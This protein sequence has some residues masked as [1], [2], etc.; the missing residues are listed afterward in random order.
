MSDFSPET[1]GAT[2]APEVYVSCHSSSARSHAAAEIAQGL[3]TRRSGVIERLEDIGPGCTST[4]VA[5]DGCSSACGARLLETHGVTPVASFT[6]DALTAVAGEEID[7]EA[8]GVVDAAER[9][10]RRGASPRRPRRSAP[11][12]AAHPAHGRSHTVDDYLL[13]IDWLTSPVGPCG[14]LVENAPT[15]AAHVSTILGVSR[16]TA[17][18]LLNRLEAQGL[19]RRGPSKEI[20]LSAEGRLLADAASRSHR[21]LERFVVETLGFGVAECFEQARRLA[22]SFDAVAID[23]LEAALGAPDR[24][25]HGWP[26]DPERARSEAADLVSLAALPLGL[27]G[28]V[29]RLPEL[30]EV[31]LAGL[32]EA[33]AVPGVAV[34]RIGGASADGFRVEI[35]GAERS[36]AGFAAAVVL[37]RLAA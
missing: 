12:A 1:D 7:P 33:G 28:I 4:V 21:I 11:A 14:A 35:D 3:A 22:P 29:E 17:G 25:P 13:A 18:E 15:L 32:E 30:D 31:A 27:R 10:V 36:V 5:V 2:A 8:P 20:V 24:C 6:L 19:V 23:R 26:V 16:P 9:L 37:V 34:R